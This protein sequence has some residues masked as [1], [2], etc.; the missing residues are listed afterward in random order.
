MTDNKKRLIN[1]FKEMPIVQVACKKA[2]VSR[3]TY[4]RWR[5]EDKVFLRESEDALNQGYELINDMSESQLVTLIKEKKLPAITHWL[6]YHHSRYGTKARSYTPITPIE[7]LTPEEDSI[8]REALA[9][10]SG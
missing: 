9:L 3:A 7:N 8:L 6:K 1:A 5:I 2:G 4:Y 10:V